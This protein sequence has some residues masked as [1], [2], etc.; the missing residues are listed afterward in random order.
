MSTKSIDDKIRTYI[1]KAMAMH[2]P[3]GDFDK[4]D[5]AIADKY[6]EEVCDLIKQ[7]QL[8]L[9]EELLNI[10]SDKRVGVIRAK[11]EELKK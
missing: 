9:L 5:I 6:T 2:H 3:A 11:M 7:S 10:Q 4:T 8:Y 1:L